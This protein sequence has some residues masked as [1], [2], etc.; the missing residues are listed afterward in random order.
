[1][2]LLDYAKTTDITFQLC[3]PNKPATEVG[4]LM[5]PNAKEQGIDLKMDLADDL[6]PF[7][8]DPEGIHRCLLNLVTNAI[9]ACLDHEPGNRKKEIVLKTVKADGW[10]VEYQVTD[11]CCGMAEEVRGKI[12]QSFF[13]TKGPRGA[14]IGLMITKKTVDAHQGII[15]VESEETKGSIFRIKLPEKPQA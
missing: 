13:S 6:T 7:Y 2:D 1:M 9:D 11:N 10:G 14:G 8:F 5:M 3:D 12:F 15:E 4:K